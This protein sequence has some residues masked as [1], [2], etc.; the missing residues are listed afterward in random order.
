MISVGS[1]NSKEE[2]RLILYIVYLRLLPIIGFKIPHLCREEHG[3]R[4]HR[5][6][7]YFVYVSG[8]PYSGCYYPGYGDRNIDQ[9]A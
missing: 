1:A 7:D 8:Y 2:E 4:Q 9:K 3:E 6:I 5:A